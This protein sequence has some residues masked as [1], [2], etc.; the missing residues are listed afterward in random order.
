VRLERLRLDR[1]RLDRWR[2]GGAGKAP[3]PVNR[4]RDYAI[5]A[6]AVAA[7]VVVGFGAFSLLRAPVTF[8]PFQ[9]AIAVAA[10]VGGA[11]PGVAATVAAAVLASIF[12]EPFGIPTVASQPEQTALA[13]FIVEGV[14]IAGLGQLVR[15][16]RAA[17]EASARE[18]AD[19]LAAE[20]AARSSAEHA[21]ARAE[22]LA[23]TAAALGRALRTEEVADIAVRE[24]LARL[25]AGQGAVGLLDSDGTTIRTISAVGFPTDAIGD[26]P[27]FALDDNVPLADAMRRREPIILRDPEEIRSRYPSVAD[28]TSEGGPAVVV[29]LIYENRA[30]GGMYF[31]YLSPA[32]IVEE[33]RSFLAA[34]GRQCASALERARL[35]DAEAR[36]AARA[37]RAER[38]RAALNKRLANRLRG[39]EAVARLGQLALLHSDL[40]PLLAAA[41]KELADV[42]D[43]DIT[44]IMEHLPSRQSLKIVAGAGWRDGVVGN[45]LISDSGQSQAG[46]ALVSDG[47]IVSRDYE[48]EER[49]RPS[50]A[51]HDHGARSGATTPILGT[52]G[53]WGVVGVHSLKPGHFAPDQIALLD[54]FAN[55]LGSAIS[56][57]ATEIALHDR[58]ERLELALAASRTG[59][60]EWNV[61]TGRVLWSD[62]ICRLHGMPPGTELASLD[63]YIAL[64]HEDDRAWVRERIEGAFETGA[65]D[66]RY[67]IVLPDGT[68][69]WTH[70]TGKVF[71]GPGRQVARMIGVGR[72]VTEEVELEAE[73]SRMAE[74]ERRANELGQAFIGVVSHE[75]RT[76][77][78]SIFAGSKLLRRMGAGQP[79]TRAELTADIEAEA[80]RLYRLTE[81]LLVLTRVERGGLEIS[82]EPVAL[83]HILE[84]VIGSEQERWPLTSIELLVQPGI[85]IAH[86][87]NTYIE[88]LIRNLV[89]NAAKYA[90]EG[91]TVQVTATATQPAAGTDPEL[92]VRVL[93]RGPG[94]AEPDLDHLFELFYRSPLTARKAPGAGIG[95]FVCNQLAQAMGGRLWAANRDGG[96]SEFGFS[97]RAYPSEPAS[98]PA[99][100]A[101]A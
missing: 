3:Q 41:A 24:G 94:L 34:L 55:V 73:R 72:D 60:W 12:R 93:D 16:G 64:I 66:A 4:P 15:S 96:G 49:F 74:A 26:W 82:L 2:L 97:L 91:G 92:Q 101:S 1:W 95:L 62:E 86:A 22:G 51:L 11:G 43:A 40:E 48:E 70:G 23:A 20:R 69:R 59:F 35:Y 29:P 46:F 13:L 10:I 83:P 32:A 47:P 30:I 71:F 18:H 79:E 52:D 14:A 17:F 68:V 84:R 19:L 45:T 21:I 81:D 78:T 37:R 87:D 63:E 31:R 77:I 36:A 99:P 44:A 75:L 6:L 100:A 67:R 89:G 58:D 25:G 7:A 38:E 53:P 33:D 9:V 76:P 90:P 28:A 57:H 85:P 42:L 27:P 65:Y 8:F 88:Q 61:S 54:T 98:A 56:R 39:Q 80:E 5:A 50:P